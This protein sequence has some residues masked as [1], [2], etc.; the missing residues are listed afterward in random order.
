[1]KLEVLV[2]VVKDGCRRQTTRAGLIPFC[3]LLTYIVSNTVYGKQTSRLC[4]PITGRDL[5]LADLF[6]TSCVK[7][8]LVSSPKHRIRGFKKRITTHTPR[9]QLSLFIR[10]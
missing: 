8:Y 9:E 2:F 5:I 4:L 1:M 6:L 7:L 10:K 3:L